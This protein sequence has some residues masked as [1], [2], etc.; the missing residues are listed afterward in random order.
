LNTAG[1]IIINFLLFSSWYVF[2]F[3]KRDVLSFADRI[4]GSF[5]LGLT[6]IIAAEMLLGVVFKKLY[7]GPLFFL[8]I[9]VSA[10]VLFFSILSMG[11][12]A[13]G[14]R[15]AFPAVVLKEIKNEASLLGRNIIEDRILLFILLLF[16][17]SVI[18]TIFLGYLFP[19]Y[20]WDAL[21]YHLPIVGN[22]I[23]SGAIQEIA[24]NSFIEQFI[25]IFPKNIELFFLWNTIFLRNDVIADLSQLMFALA[26]VL[27]V[28]SIAVKLNIRE[29]Y[30]VYSSLLFFFT[31]IIILQSTTNY[32]DIAIAV[33]FLIAV[34]FLTDGVVS[35]D[36]DNTTGAEILRQRSFKI[37]LAGLTTGILLGSKGSGP[38]FVAVLSVVIVINEIRKHMGLRKKTSLSMHAILKKSLKFYLVYFLLPVFLLGGYWYMKNWVLYGSPVY[39]MEISVFNVKIFKGLYNGIVEP[40]PRIIDELSYLTRPLYVWSENTKYYLYDSRLG[41]LGPI[42]FILFLPAVVFSLCYAVIKRRKKFLVIS[43]IFIAVFLMYPR[44]WTPRYVIFMVGLGALS[45]GFVLDYFHGRDKVLRIIA[46]LLTLY[47][48]VVANSPCITPEQIK[49]FIHLPPKERTIGWLAPFNIDIHA[50][51]EYGHWI[52]ISRNISARDTLAYTFEPFFHSPLWNSGFSSRIT[53]INSDAYKKWL[54]E[55]KVNNVTH[56]LFRRNSKEDKWIKKEKEIFSEMGWLGGLKEKFKV[57]YSDENYKIVRFNGS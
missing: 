32:V 3:N 13:S 11:K 18:W 16:A 1:Y 35:A 56:V 45:F 24:V 15:T 20:T 47:T 23:Q 5:V 37:F 54:E 33:L 29:K 43:L 2:L 8:N 40:V 50:R 19:S 9:S 28:Y 42:W 31:P 22:I 57:V 38:L 21:W 10:G 14:N 49:K 30:A 6:Q 4:I 12:A 48:F 53:Y 46:L 34:N 52:W 17:V 41:G 27:A 51:Q 44:N 36:S 39:P 55:L 25:N 7:A 26:G